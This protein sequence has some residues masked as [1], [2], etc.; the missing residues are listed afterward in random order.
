MS[1]SLSFIELLHLN[2][3]ASETTGAKYCRKERKEKKHAG[4]LGCH[5]KY[6]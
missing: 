4:M 1:V 2:G 6:F 3:G 5:V